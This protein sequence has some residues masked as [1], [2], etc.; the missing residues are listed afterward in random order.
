MKLIPHR[1]FLNYGEN[2]VMGIITA[3]HL[4][5]IVEFDISFIRGKWMLCHDIKSFHFHTESFDS[6]LETI[7]KAPFLHGSLI[8]DIKWDPIYN[9]NHVFKQAIYYLGKIIP[10]DLWQS[11][12]QWYFQVQF[13][14]Q[15]LTL[16]SS[17]LPGKKGCIVEQFETLETRHLDYLMIDLKTICPLDLRQKKRNWK[18]K[19]FFGFTVPSLRVLNYYEQQFSCLDKFVM[20]MVLEDSKLLS[21]QKVKKKN[22]SDSRRLPAE[23]LF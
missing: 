16:A 3:L 10:R 19:E 20:D 6:L 8:V 18:N 15:L 9:K 11:N 4:C 1:G 5:K 21:S 2:T 7:L 14:C 13:S 23:S 22:V 12:F 17:K